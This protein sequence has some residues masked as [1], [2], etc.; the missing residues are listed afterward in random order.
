MI[1]ESSNAM[2]TIMA[3]S[4]AIAMILIN[5]VINRVVIRSM[6]QWTLR[7]ILTRREGGRIIV[8][9]SNVMATIMASSNSIV[10]IL[11]MTVI[12]VVVVRPMGVDPS[13][14]SL[15]AITMVVVEI[16]G[17]RMLVLTDITIIIV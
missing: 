11:I 14:V 1:V 15:T 3:S 2:A 10:I 6:F 16:R 8:I 12:N 4:N 5:A 9:S 17:G 7:D 13:M